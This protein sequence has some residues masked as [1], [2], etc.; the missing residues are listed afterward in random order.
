MKLYNINLENF[1]VDLGK[2]TAEVNGRLH[3]FLL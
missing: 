3:V 1:E 2:G